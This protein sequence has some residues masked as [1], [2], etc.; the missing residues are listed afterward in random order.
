M[1]M[2]RAVFV[3]ASLAAVALAACASRTTSGVQQP[4]DSVGA[5]SDQQ[6]AGGLAGDFARAAGD[7]IYF[8]YDQAGLSA[9][10]RRTLQAQA[11]WLQRH[12]SVRVLIAG[13]CDERGTREYN[14]ALGARRAAAARDYLISLGVAPARME[15][16][17]YGKDRPVDPRPNEQGWA[18]NRNAHTSLQPAA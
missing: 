8:A 5:P 18:V 10:A 16:V 1:L 6:D 17:S 13:N 15:M 2:R 4:A 3:L 9:E 14:L 11:A 12:A 7:R